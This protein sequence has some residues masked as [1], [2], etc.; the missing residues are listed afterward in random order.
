LF[1][2]NFSDE[3]ESQDV[4]ASL[5]QAGQ[6][7]GGVMDDVAFLKQCGI[8]VDMRWLAEIASQNG[9][10]EISNY[11]TSLF[12]IAGVLSGYSLEPQQLKLL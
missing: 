6:E 9:S 2:R 11:T 3:A 1:E 5:H 8:E 10:T 7:L 12:R 4:A